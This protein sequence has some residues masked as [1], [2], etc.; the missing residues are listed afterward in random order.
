MAAAS[1]DRG[2]CEFVLLDLKRK[3]HQHILKIQL[4]TLQKITFKKLKNCSS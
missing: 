4:I 1:P 2:L 3:W